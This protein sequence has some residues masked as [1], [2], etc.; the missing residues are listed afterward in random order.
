VTYLEVLRLM[1]HAITDSVVGGCSLLS[2]A[3]S[4]EIRGD[5]KVH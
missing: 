5:K 3:L 1:V 4:Y 2:L